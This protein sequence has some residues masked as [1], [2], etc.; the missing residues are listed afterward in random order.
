MITFTLPREL[1]SFVWHHQE[2]AYKTL[3]AVTADI[4]KTFYKNDKGLG[5][6][7]GFTGILHTHSRR[8][9]FHPHVH[10]IVPNGGV[11]KKQPLWKQKNNKYLFNGRA[12]AIRFRKQF[13]EA[14]RDEGFFVPANV[15]EKWIAQC[16]KVGKGEPALVYMARYL[17]RGVISEKDIIDHSNGNITF[18]YQDSQTK[19]RVTRT[20]TAIEFLW[21]I[22][23]HV[24]PTG[25]RRVRD[26][27]F[28]H[29]NAKKTLQR[30]Q[31]LLR[32]F[33]SDFTEKIKNQSH[34]LAVDFPCDLWV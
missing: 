15:P 22:L 4:I 16:K 2:W 31:L 9:D 28:L 17:Y 24:L 8:K 33:L 27:G 3:F 11:H 12:L 6:E 26:Y 30:I 32:V 21:L 7:P 23:Q 1:R 18:S 14:M 29:G 10:Y 19:K 20:Q 25:F 34:A 13:L 5:V